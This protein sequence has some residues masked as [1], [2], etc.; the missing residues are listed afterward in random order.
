M[1]KIFI[2]LIAGLITCTGY[3]Q[4]FKPSTGVYRI[5]YANGTNVHVSRDHQTHTPLNRVDMHGHDG[6]PYNHRGSRKWLDSLYS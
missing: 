3:S 1:N 5:P 2:I 4:T 6:A